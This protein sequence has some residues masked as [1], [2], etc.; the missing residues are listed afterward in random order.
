MKDTQHQVNAS[1][2]HN[3]ML[4]HIN[5]DGYFFLGGDGYFLKKIITSAAK[6]IE[7]SVQR[8]WKKHTS[9]IRM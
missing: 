6:G 9:H 3:D 5:W 8:N 7:K 2:N 1:Q 4:R